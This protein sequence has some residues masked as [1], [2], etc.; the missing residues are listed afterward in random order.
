MIYNVPQKERRLRLR[1]ATTFTC[2][3]LYNSNY[4]TVDKSNLLD[5]VANRDVI[6]LLWSTKVESMKTATCFVRYVLVVVELVLVH[7]CGNLI[8]FY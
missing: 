5:D 2:H 1:L 6:G 3:A 8:L 4:Y 7:E